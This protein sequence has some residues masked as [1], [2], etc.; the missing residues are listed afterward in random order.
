MH[1]ATPI[2]C[3]FNVGGDI[4]TRAEAFEELTKSFYAS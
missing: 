3:N 1:P 2:R 4:N